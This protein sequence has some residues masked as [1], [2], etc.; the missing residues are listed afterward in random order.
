MREE[1]DSRQYG[2]CCK[3]VEDCSEKKGYFGRRNYFFGEFDSILGVANTAVFFVGVKDPLFET[4]SVDGRYA[5]FA[6]A[7]RQKGIGG[8]AGVFLADDTGSFVVRHWSSVFSRETWCLVNLELG[9]YRLAS[10]I[11]KSLK[12]SS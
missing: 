9:W 2:H 10:L 3:I 12:I 4:L 7:G 1:K 5:S 8:G 6:A 11:E